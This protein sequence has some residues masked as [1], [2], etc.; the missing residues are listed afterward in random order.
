MDAPFQRVGGIL[1][2]ARKASF[3]AAEAIRMMAA[4]PRPMRIL[5]SPFESW[6]PWIERGFRLS[7]SPHE[8]VFADIASAPLEAFD[9]VIPVTGKDVRLLSAFG[10]RMARNPIP[11]PSIDAIDLCEDKQRFKERLVAEGFGRYVPGIGKDLRRPYVLKGRRGANGRLTHMVE[12]SQDEERLAAELASP[13]FFAEEIVPGRSE[14]ATHVIV[15][16]GRV[17]RSL[18]IRY[19]FA[20]D[21]H[22]MGRSPYVHRS[23]CRC[24]H[25]DVLSD[26]L[27]AIGF[28]GLCCFDYKVVDGVPKILELNPRLGGSLTPYL[29]SF[30]NGLERRA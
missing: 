15:R 7:R 24:P 17:I 6:R 12:A 1:A 26:M 16:G 3:L 20:S 13:E 4:P 14:Y 11:I 18:T 21:R 5:L 30:V 2:S 23:P 28:E 29:F 27:R 9:L 8:L 22:V 25:P 10:G 19:A